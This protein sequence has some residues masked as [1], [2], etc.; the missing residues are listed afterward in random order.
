[1]TNRRVI[2]IMS[3][4]SGLVA[5]YLHLAKIGKT[6]PLRCGGEVGC[7]AVQGSIYGQLFGIDV[8]LLGAVFYGLI[9]LIATVGSL[10]SFADDMRPTLALMALIYSGFAYTLWLKYAEFVILKG[11]CQWCVVSAVT[12]TVSTVL[13]TLDWRR[14]RILSFRSRSST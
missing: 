8:A 13:V 14:Q 11:F 3:L 4:I 1:M 10:D 5:V 12:I 6:E 2:A 9:F 7:A